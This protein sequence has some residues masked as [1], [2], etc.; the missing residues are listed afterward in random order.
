MTPHDGSLTIAVTITE[1]DRMRGDLEA[2]T[3]LLNEAIAERDALSR[4]LN[5]VI[6]ELG[7]VRA[8][9]TWLAQR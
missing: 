2:T 3:Y 6:G 8:Q 5:Q 1:I 9:L 7:E 4:Q